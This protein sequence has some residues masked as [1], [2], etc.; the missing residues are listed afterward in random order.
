M[1]TGK[2]VGDKE[3]TDGPPESSNLGLLDQIA[4]RIHG[5][6]LSRE[7][8]VP[9]KMKFPGKS[10]RGNERDPCFL[11]YHADE[12]VDDDDTLDLS[13]NTEKGR[14]DDNYTTS[15]ISAL[16]SSFSLLAFWRS[17]ETDDHRLYIQNGRPRNRA[18]SYTSS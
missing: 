5:L 9:G 15:S 6:H 11:F 10:F 8:K 13:Q 17:P 3:D 1:L 4:E 7:F 16:T 2:E 12:E 18:G 14:E